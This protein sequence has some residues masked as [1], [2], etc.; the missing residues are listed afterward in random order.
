M[1]H[2]SANVCI[3]YRSRF[4]VPSDALSARM[5]KRRC[6]ADRELEAAMLEREHQLQ[7]IEATRTCLSHVSPGDRCPGLSF[8]PSVMMTP[9]SPTALP[10]WNAA[11]LQLT[12]CH[13]Q[14]IHDVDLKTGAQKCREKSKPTSAQDVR[15]ADG[16]HFPHLSN[17]LNEIIAK[18][19]RDCLQTYAVGTSV[20]SPHLTSSLTSGLPN[21]V[22]HFSRTFLDNLPLSD[23]PAAA[24]IVGSTM[25]RIGERNRRLLPEAFSSMPNTLTGDWDRRSTKAGDAVLDVTATRTA[26]LSCAIGESAKNQRQVQQ[27]QATNVTNVTIRKPFSFTVESLLAR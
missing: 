4:P 23:A 24:L 2:H 10:V 26:R 3:A 13:S 11:P 9:P 27:S 18:T 20:S 16:R 7:A 8:P 22:T 1:H 6:F 25:D 5:R 14:P 12:A 17:C 19:G 15:F 21:P